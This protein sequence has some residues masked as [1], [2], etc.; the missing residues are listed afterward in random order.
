MNKKF[1]NVA[2]FG[3]LIA[4]S[5]STFTSCKDYD[6]DIDGLTNRVSA[7]EGTLSQLESLIKKGA[8]I[9]DVKSTANGVVVTLSDNK[10][11][12][13]TNGKDGAAGATGA[14]GA[15]GKNGTVVTM[16]EDGY[17]Y[18]D[19][20]KTENPW[21][22]EKGN[23]GVAGTPGTNGTPGAD[24]VT[25]DA[26][27]F[28][29]GTEGAAAGYWVKVTVKADGTKTEEIQST[30]W[31]P[32]SSE[33][34]SAVWDTENGYLTLSGVAGSEAPI[35]IKLTD[36]LRSLAF[37]PEVI[38][39]KTGLGAI[40]FYALL[41]KNEGTGKY[42]FV[43]STNP[44]VTYRLNPQNA[45]V[46]NV[47]WSFINRVVESRVAGDNTD[48]IKIMKSEKD[49]KGGMNFTLQTLK[50]LDFLKKE[51]EHAIIA[52]KA[53]N[54]EDASEIV[55]NYSVV[56]AKELKKFGIAKVK[57]G[58]PIA[59]P[60][61]FYPT[62]ITAVAVNSPS[63]A[64]LVFD[65]ELDL[66]PIVMA[67]AKEIDQSLVAAGVAEDEISYVYS[68][69]D[70]F[71]CKNP[72]DEKKTDQNEFISLDGSVVKVDKEWLNKGTAALG[73]TPVVK[74]V[75]KVKG[76]EMATGFVK[77]EIVRESTVAPDL[78]DLVVTIPVGDIEYSN[79]DAKDGFKKVMDWK[80]VNAEIYDKLGLSKEDFAN[81]YNAP[82]TEGVSPT[83]VNVVAN[84]PGAAGVTGT[85]MIELTID[86][87][88]A[89]YNKPDKQEVAI[90]YPAKNNKTHRNV[91]VKFTY[92]IKHVKAL[93]VLNPD[94]L[95][96]SNIIQVKG[97]MEGESWKLISEMKEQCKNYLSDYT[98]PGNH[99]SLKF[100]F[101]ATT[102]V[103]EGAVITGT[104]Y[105]DQTIKLTK[106]FTTEEDHR[107]Y[108]IEMVATMANGE[109]CVK[110]YTVR[111]VRPFN[112]E[113]DAITLKT[114][115]ATADSKDMSQLVVIK[116]RDD[117]VVYE[118]GTYTEYGKNTYKLDK[119]GLSF[120]YDVKADASF[121]DKLTVVNT[122]G[123]VEWYNGGNDLQQDKT[124]QSVATITIP[125]IATIKTTGDIKVLSTEHSK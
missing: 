29:P 100:R 34:V 7:V 96:G 35:K 12:T 1:L 108:Q 88:V 81:N 76:V 112:A 69:N 110:E 89:F 117:K 104:D 28:Y 70:K 47:E 106:P 91:I 39:S 68:K 85:N 54:K 49:G 11:F 86:N 98:L 37:V 107:D 74:V 18:V 24:G 57:D 36:T 14:T 21:K 61:S 23:D 125:Q 73:R 58:K 119:A 55:S 67:W 97:K 41:H 60:T 82:S 99:T 26:V 62:E 113:I 50:T 45:D 38:D 115:T 4:V 8:V 51:N 30:E 56:T 5:S 121:G 31:A 25:P 75:A 48:L 93:P 92:N 17:W 52:L 64:E 102:P 59:E 66:A 101:K 114:F 103:Q 3:T 22:G 116:D 83:G 109:E 120:T 27:Y 20:K 87:R 94:Y 32:K 44:T 118:K 78:E 65:K 40:D 105:K 42:E 2:L 15:A 80:A 33:T 16:G 10:T 77:I 46:K 13:L 71:L 53:T 6:D 95:I 19:G 72:E 43:T 123:I 79:I 122:T 124:A 63:D 90:K 111:F 9:T 84:M